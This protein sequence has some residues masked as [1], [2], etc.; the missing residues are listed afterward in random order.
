MAFQARNVLKYGLRG[1]GAYVGR[2]PDQCKLGASRVTDPEIKE[3]MNLELGGESRAVT[4]K[5]PHISF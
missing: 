5:H 4:E 1:E 3:L 2:R